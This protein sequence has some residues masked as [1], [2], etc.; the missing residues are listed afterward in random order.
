[1]SFTY[2]KIIKSLGLIALTLATVSTAVPVQ[3]ENVRAGAHSASLTA[4]APALK[5]GI[6][7]QD[8]DTSVKPSEDFFNYAI[9]GWRVA[10]PIPNDQ[11]RW[12]SFVILN[13]NNTKIVNSM[14]EQA[15]RDPQNEL[16]AK[17]GD[18]YASGMNVT[19][20][21]REGISPIRNELNVIASID[22][23][24]DLVQVI[25]YL[26]AQ[27]INPYFDLAIGPDDKNSEHVIAHL[28]Q[29]GLG[30]PERDY[31]L[32]DDERSRALRTKYV[33]HM[34]KMFRL[35]GDTPL[36]AAKEAEAVMKL[37]TKLAK[38]SLAAAELRDP[39][40]IYH[41]MSLKE[42][43]EMAPDF[44]WRPY[45]SMLGLKKINQ[46]NVM[47]PDFVTAFNKELYKDTPLV[48]HLSYLRWNVINSSASYLS[49]DMAEE[50][51]NFYSKELLGVAVMPPR[52]KIVSK[53]VSSIGMM[54]FAVGE[55][56]TKQHFSP[57]SKA[58][59]EEITTNITKVFEKEIPEQ[60]W[61]TPATQKEA[62]AK[63]HS[64]VSKIGYPEYT[65]DYS[66]LKIDRIGF[67][68]NVRNARRFEVAR[69]L[70]TF[71]KPVDRTEWHMTPQTVNAYYNP[72]S[73]EIV[74]P[75]GILQPP[76]FNV[77]VDD[78]ANYGAIGAVIGHEMSH[79]YDDM[80]AQ[81]D[82]KGNLRNWWQEEDLKAFQQLAKGVEEQYAGY[83][84]GGTKM[85]G[86]LVLGEALA[87][88]NGLSLAWKAYQLAH[89]G[90]KEVII[91][92]YTP[93]QRFFL[94]FARVW[95]SNV[96][97]EY[98]QVQVNTDPHP[99]AMWRV[100]GTV[101]NMPAFFE[102]FKVKEGEPMRRPAEKI[103]HIW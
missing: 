80:G 101:S 2:G 4:S 72:S 34:T 70:A 95:A 85:N 51:F 26:H 59:V 42:L 43:K 54:G 32:R 69:K 23:I 88:L 61:M 50:H 31:Y 9:G 89:Q 48:D 36:A 45:F 1:M 35:I 46:L 93:A 102:A 57:A 86:K 84:V 47:M 60:K 52:W 7:P 62:L 56:F 67:Y 71:D 10:N 90:E 18:F 58:K 78:A 40:S 100:N 44:Q 30:L 103:N 11:A 79:G 28:S 82:A 33:E 76:F 99:H 37:E 83:S 21:D 73:N 68:D 91:D 81:Y 20:I 66:K 74:F 25:A 98:E 39:E 29:G 64:F 41:M 96:K 75:A 3:A 87:D 13:E 8:F 14:L 77:E 92:G 19:N 53:T 5:S 15:A 22:D 16:E 17:L 97:P 38:A 12:G 55:M 63:L 27:D 49:A 65:R 94:A 6:N 24:E